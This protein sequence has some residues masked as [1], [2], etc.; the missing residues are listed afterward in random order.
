[1]TDFEKAKR[2]LARKQEKEEVMRKVKLRSSEH[3]ADRFDG[4]PTDVLA[5]VLEKRKR[6]I[7]AVSTVLLVVEI[8]MLAGGILLTLYSYAFIIAIAL[9]NAMAVFSGQCDALIEPYDFDTL[10]LLF[11]GPTLC[12]LF[13]WLSEIRNNLATSVNRGDVSNEIEKRKKGEEQ[14]A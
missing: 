14:D 3:R 10:F 5:F 9:F 13:W 12:V 4:V 7:H 2:E 8:P 1:M 11:I 6:R